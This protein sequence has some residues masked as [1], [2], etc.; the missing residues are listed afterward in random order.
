MDDILVHGH[1]M[2]EH[3]QRL[4]V[5]LSKL[6]KAGLVLNEKKCVFAVLQ[7]KFLRHINAYFCQN[8]I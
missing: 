7:V 8:G 3:N 5:V 1:T 6:K 4:Q 2:A